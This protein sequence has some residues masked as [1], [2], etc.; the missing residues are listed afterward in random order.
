MDASDASNKIDKNLMDEVIHQRNTIEKCGAEDRGM[1][2]DIDYAKA[3]SYCSSILKNC[4][5]AVHYMCLRV[6]FLLLTNQLQEAETFIEEVIKRP[7]LPYNSLFF[8][9]R[10]T[11]EIYTGR[12]LVGENLLRQVLGQDPDNR[13]AANCLKLIKVAA[14]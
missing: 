1:N 9:D 14:K 2:E 7:E 13:E 8:E 3:A 10:A 6:K 12:E 4:P 5:V 11:A